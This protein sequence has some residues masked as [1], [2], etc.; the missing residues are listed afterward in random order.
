MTMPGHG[1]VQGQ[2]DLRGRERAYLG[3]VDLAGKRVLEIGTASGHLCF[4]ME[5]QGAEVCGYD[6]SPEQDWDIVPFHDYDY[7]EQVARRKEEIRQLN[8]SWWYAH[9]HFRSRSRVVYGSVYD[10]SP[11]LGRFDIVTM[12][13]ILLHL[14]DPFLA[15]QRAACLATETLIV[16]DLLM[17]SFDQAAATVLGQG[18]IVRFMPDART[19]SPPGLW[20]GLSPHFVA[21]AAR[22]LGF[23]RVQFSVHRQLHQSGEKDLYT[24]V[25]SRHAICEARRDDT[26][27]N[28]LIM[29]NFHYD[30]YLLNQI[31]MSRILRFVGYRFLK[32]LGLAQELPHKP[33]ARLR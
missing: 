4:W 29:D 16:T 3:N 25:A 12:G 11:E 26:E 1:E 14:R 19:C 15:L 23:R 6:L 21:E 5:Q 27:C 9:H 28:R 32:G 8:N 33:E 10:L 7:S 20:W 18:R 24:I 31:P 30:Q 2:W 22:V 17:L 13:S